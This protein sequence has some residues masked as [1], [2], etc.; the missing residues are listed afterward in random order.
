VDHTD[1]TCWVADTGNEEV[2]QV[3]VDTYELQDLDLHDSGKGAPRSISVNPT[4]GTVWLA[5]S[6]KNTVE[7][8]L[9]DYL[10]F[11]VTDDVRSDEFVYPR[12][13]SADPKRV[14]V[15][16]PG[17]YFGH[18]WHQYCWVAD[19]Y[20]GRV[21]RIHEQHE[22]DWLPPFVGSLTRVS[23][24]VKFAEDFLT[25]E[26]VSVNTEDR[27]CWVAD[28][29]GGHVAHLDRDCEELWRKS[30]FSYPLSVSVN[31]AD[32]SCWVADSMND[33]VVHLAENGAG[34]LRLGGFKFPRSVSADAGDGT[35]WVADTLNNQVVHLAENGTELWRGGSFN[36][37]HAVCVDPT[38][39]SCWVADTGNDQVVHLVVTEGPPRAYFTAAPL[40]GSA[41]LEVTFIDESLRNPTSWSWDFGDGGTSDEQHPS[42]E[43]V[44][45]G[46]YEVTL[47]AT[48]AHGSDSETEPLF[49]TVAFSDLPADHWACGEILS[50]AGAGI[51]AGYDDGSYQ[52]DNPV[53]RDQ[54]AAY[55]SRALAGGD[56]GVPE[57]TGTPTFPDVGAEHWALDYVEYAAAQN[58]VAGYGDGSYHPEEQVN[59]A[60]MAVY[61]ARALVAP[62]GEAGLADYVP[63]DPRNFSDVPTDH[64]AYTHVE[65]CVENGVVAGYEDGNYHPDYTVTRDQMA[66]YVARAFGLMV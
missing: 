40:A 32:G 15:D 39:G 25:P 5:F 61:V 66:V 44:D 38:D 42:H 58:V 56:E 47:T 26:S 50:C 34:L 10:N 3:T 64:W 36:Q 14:R 9:F 33:Q 43:Y 46:V 53:T 19:T 37:P 65:Y 8:Q 22:H 62:E 2:V 49:I 11:W 35:C 51:V 28:S 1:G 52:P 16:M 54:M 24:E 27:S 30:C 55:V 12:S 48:N 29:A 20:R 18:I 63:A 21:A 31:S 57:F 13:V 7:H 59:R 4:D 45:L 60:Q 23:W 6:E 17:G 41:P